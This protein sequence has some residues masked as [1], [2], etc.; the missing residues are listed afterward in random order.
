[1]NLEIPKNIEEKLGKH[2]EQFGI[3]VGEL[4]KELLEYIPQ[5]QDEYPTQSLAKQ[6]YIAYRAL[7]TRLAQEE[8][9]LRSK[10]IVHTAFF[11]GGTG[12]KDE[13]EKKIKKLGSISVVRY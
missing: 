2:S 5:V 6:M 11:I 7:T 8:G 9:G 4:K 1:M 13:A 3:K 10:S 12:I